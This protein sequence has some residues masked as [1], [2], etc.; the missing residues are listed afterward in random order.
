LDDK[1]EGRGD[2]GRRFQM[3]EPAT[4]KDPLMYAQAT[5]DIRPFLSFIL[6]FRCLGYN[7]CL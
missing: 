5:I 4:E 1:N 3:E 2:G 6:V 7:R